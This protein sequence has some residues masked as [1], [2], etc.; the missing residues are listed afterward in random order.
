MWNTCRTSPVPSFC[1]NPS[2]LMRYP[3]KSATSHSPSTVLV[4][5]ESSPLDLN[6]TD[7][8]RCVTMDN[9]CV[10]LDSMYDQYVRIMEDYNASCLAIQRQYR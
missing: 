7:L 6:T 8:V 5:S 4:H 2:S 10:L 1:R 9:R 3:S